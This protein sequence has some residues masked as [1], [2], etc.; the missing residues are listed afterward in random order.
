[1][2]SCF[3]LS[4]QVLDLVA[5]ES[6]ALSQSRRACRPAKALGGLLI[7]SDGERQYQRSKMKS[8]GPGSAFG[9]S[10]SSPTAGAMKNEAFGTSSSP[11]SPT[12]ATA[13]GSMYQQQLQHPLVMLGRESKREA[14]SAKARSLELAKLAETMRKSWDEPKQDADLQR[15]EKM[16]VQQLMQRQA[17]EVVHVVNGDW[18]K[19]RRRDF[20]LSVRGYSTI[21]SRLVLLLSLLLF[22]FF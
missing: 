3:F 9:V 14:E 15:R 22:Y 2:C 19:G 11:S 20:P 6:A 4:N 7:P 18:R 16:A 1:M 5:K 8:S 12:H 13:S 17:H 21:T 10:S